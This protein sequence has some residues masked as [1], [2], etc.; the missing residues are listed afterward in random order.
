MV[1]GRGGGGVRRV[2]AIADR[3]A[4]ERVWNEGGREREKREKIS[5][6]IR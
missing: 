1:A 6:K 3:A 4:S 2:L 5:A